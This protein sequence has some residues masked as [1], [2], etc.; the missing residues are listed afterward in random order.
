MPT[1]INYSFQDCL[2]SEVESIA[3]VPGTLL[4]CRDTGDM[5][6]DTL[7]GERIQNGKFIKM[8]ENDSERTDIL[9]PNS[10]LIYVVKNS[11]KIW[12]F[13]NG[14][15]A[16]LNNNSSGYITIFNVEV[17]SGASAT[18]ND[19]GIS[20]VMVPTFYP[21]PAIADLYDSEKVTCVTGTGTVTITN[22]SPYPMYG[23]I[24]IV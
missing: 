22:E 5:F 14:G 4:F 12:I 19:V 11:G 7:E 17:A 2:A 21:I 1:E 24:Y 10:D 13:H 18:Y 6:Y 20:T 23:T 16:C 9:I 8:L 15:W 3:I